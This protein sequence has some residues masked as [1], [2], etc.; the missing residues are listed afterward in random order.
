[1]YVRNMSE[2]KNLKRTMIGPRL[3]V[4]FARLNRKQFVFMS[5]E[6]FLVEIFAALERTHVL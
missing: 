1:M 4:G 3:S 5:T 6:N 2:R